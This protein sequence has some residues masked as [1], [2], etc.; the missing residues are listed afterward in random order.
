MIVAIPI[1]MESGIDFTAE[2]R[3]QPL[4]YIIK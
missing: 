2:F 1:I 4:V 3:G